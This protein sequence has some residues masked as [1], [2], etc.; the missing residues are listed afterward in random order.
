MQFVKG[1]QLRSVFN[2]IN[3]VTRNYNLKNLRMGCTS[4]GRH[5]YV[6]LNPWTRETWEHDGVHRLTRRNM[7]NNGGERTYK[8]EP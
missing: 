2:Q 1:K 6:R 3:V 4:S 8:G 5:R 7:T